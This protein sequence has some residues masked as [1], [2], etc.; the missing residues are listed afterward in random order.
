MYAYGY[1]KPV[2]T[3]TFTVGVSGDFLNGDS[4]EIS[5][6]QVNPKFG[7]M[8]NPAPATTV[9]AAA[10][11]GL[12]AHTEDGPDARA[13]AGRRIRA[14]FQDDIN[15]ASSWRYGVGIDQKFASD[16]FVGAEASK[17]DLKSPFVN[18]DDPENPFLVKE[19]IKEYFGRA[20]AFWTPHPWFALSAQYLYERLE[21]EGLSDVPQN[22]KTERVPVAAKFFH[23][24]GSARTLPPPTSTRTV[25]WSTEPRS[26]RHLPSSMRC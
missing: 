6:S 26:A 18:V 8:W 14:V 11:Q 20:Y 4:I 9:R 7:V 23:P 10:F 13:D 19:N 3:V 12:E 21:S 2:N 22:L 25:H 16:L 24:S 15:G 1:F 17:R 5:G